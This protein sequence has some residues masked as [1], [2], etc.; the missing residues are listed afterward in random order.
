MHFVDE[1]Q[2]E[3]HSVQQQ[4]IL[5]L[6]F[7][8]YW[9]KTTVLRFHLQPLLICQSIRVIWK[10]WSFSENK[11]FIKDHEDQNQMN[12]KVELS[13]WSLPIRHELC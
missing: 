10:L 11:Y 8:Y 6:Q 7:L 9:T 13:R 4:R 12:E 1:I 2:I 5:Q 3:L